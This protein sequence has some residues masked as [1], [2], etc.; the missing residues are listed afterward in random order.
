M[1]EA[2]VASG[3]L[4][5]VTHRLENE[6]RGRLP[7]TE[8][9]ES[10]AVAVDGAY[11]AVARGRAVHSLAPGSGRPPQIWRSTLGTKIMIFAL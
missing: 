6:W 2:L 1:L 5:G 8:I 11:D 3:F 7:R 10:V 9:E 4:D